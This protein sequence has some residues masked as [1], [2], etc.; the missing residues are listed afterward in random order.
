MSAAARRLFLQ[1]ILTTGDDKC[2]QEQKKNVLRCCGSS[3]CAPM[4]MYVENEQQLVVNALAKLA[5]LNSINF[6]SFFLWQLLASPSTVVVLPCI[7]KTTVF[8]VNET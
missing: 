4:G 6:F 2:E 3:L 7:L 8:K 1:D 5:S